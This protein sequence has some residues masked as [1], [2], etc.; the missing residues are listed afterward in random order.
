MNQA[1]INNDMNAAIFCVTE[2]ASIV[3]AIMKALII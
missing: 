2:S 3:P 1:K